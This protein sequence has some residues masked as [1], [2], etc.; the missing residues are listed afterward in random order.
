MHDD[1]GLRLFAMSHTCTERID[2]GINKTPCSVK[3]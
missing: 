1:G 2:V 3:K